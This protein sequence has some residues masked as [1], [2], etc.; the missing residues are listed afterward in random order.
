MLIIG[1]TVIYN[2]MHYILNQKIGFDK[3]QVVMLQGTNTLGDKNIKSF[4]NELSKLAS[5]KS[6]SISDYL[7][8][9]GANRNG[10]QFF[11]DG[12]S[13]L[14]AEVGGQFWQIDD[15][16]L[17]TLGMKLVEGRNFSYNMSDDT[18]GKTVIINQTLAKRLNLK[19]PIGAKITNGYTF[20]VIGVVQDFNFDSMHNQIGPLALHFGLNPSL[21]SVKVRNGDMKSTP[22]L[23]HGHLEAICTRSA[24]TLHLPGRKLRQHVCRCATDGP[25]FHHVCNTGYRHRMPG[26]VCA[27]CL[28]G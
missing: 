10:N 9:A 6:V 12:R 5:V 4:K 16:Y 19:N 18:A 1:T 21:V 17:K 26:P 15:T 8:V 25:Y 23:D 14:D 22:A 28:Y 3:D 7:P 24:H 11:I 13:K 2:Q 20:T 27:F